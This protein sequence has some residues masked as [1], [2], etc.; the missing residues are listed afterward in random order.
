MLSLRAHAI[1]CASLFAT[2]LLI[3]PVAGALQSSGLIKNPAAYKYPAMMIVGGL[4]IAFAF[5]AVP[6]MVKLVLGFQRAI[7]NQNV[8]AIRTVLTLENVIIWTMWALMAAGLLIAVPAAIADGAFGWQPRRAL[9]SLSVGQSRGVLV[10]G[11]GMT[12]D[13]MVRGSSLKLNTPAGAAVIS[14]GEVFDFQIPGST[15]VF[16][17]CRYYFIST[18]THDRSRIQ[19]ISIGTSHEKLTRAERDA[20]DAA[21]RG[22]LAADG[23]LTGHELYRDEE[24][25]QLHGGLTRGP[26]GRV[27]LK[28]G[29]VLTIESSRVDEVAPGEDPET[30]L[31]WIQAISLWS[32]DDYPGF[33]RFVFA[34]P[35]QQASS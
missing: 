19:G 5:S 9:E 34:P 14:A 11:P 26:E 22:R 3:V 2:L 7:G 35:Q 1:I 18:F 4:V 27:W 20:A 28:D 31:V 25:Q 30:A 12:V 21:L 29:T 16:P 8:P 23:W 24:D 13:E 6:V 32:A 15:I 17:G 10:A 33:D